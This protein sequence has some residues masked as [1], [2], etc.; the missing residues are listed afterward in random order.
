MVWLFLL[1]FIVSFF[2]GVFDV[3]Q[4]IFLSVFIPFVLALLYMLYFPVLFERDVNKIMNFLRKSKQAHY[5]FIYHY[6]MIMLRRL[7][8]QFLG[9][10]PSK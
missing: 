10:V 4:W 9:S 1:L 5:Q 2:M 7:K 8:K 3:P 6:I